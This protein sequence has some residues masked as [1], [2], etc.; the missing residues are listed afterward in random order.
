MQPSR[1][2]TITKKFAFSK[3]F[4]LARCHVL[5][6]KLLFESRA[7]EEGLPWKSHLQP[8][9]P[10]VTIRKLGLGSKGSKAQLPQSEL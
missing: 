7:P 1:S 5:G 3:Q 2:L 9:S 6:R 8:P 10:V 4:Y